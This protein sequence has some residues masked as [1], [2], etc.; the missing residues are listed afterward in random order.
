MALNLAPFS[1]WTLPDKT[2]QRRLALRCHMKPPSLY[3]A[4][5]LH[6]LRVWLF[7]AI[8]MVPLGVALQYLPEWLFVIVFFSYG[9]FIFFPVV[10]AFGPLGR[11]IGR[12]LNEAAIAEAHNE[13][14]KS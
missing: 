7:M 1:R 4:V 12:K 10:F 9:I 5:L 2:A 8:S 6:G 11:R 14:S 13:R 3:R